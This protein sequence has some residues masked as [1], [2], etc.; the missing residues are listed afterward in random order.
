MRSF[1]G[2]SSLWLV[3]GSDPAAFAGLLLGHAEN[4]AFLGSFRW[5]GMSRAFFLRSR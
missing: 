3:F 5:R 1:R 2:I 4:K